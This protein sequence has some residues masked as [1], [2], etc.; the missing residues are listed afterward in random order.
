MSLTLL[1]A[2]LFIADL[3][4]V[5]IVLALATVASRAD[6]RAEREIAEWRER[7]AAEAS[8]SAADPT[9]YPDVRERPGS[10]GARAA[11]A[12]PGL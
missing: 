1:I 8:A 10:T 6:E 3:L 7:R 11:G 5:A 4:V 9:P 12:R 2:A